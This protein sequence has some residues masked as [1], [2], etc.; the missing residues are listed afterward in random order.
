MCRSTRRPL[1]DPSQTGTP[2]VWFSTNITSHLVFARFRS[3]KKVRGVVPGAGF[4]SMPKSTLSD[5]IVSRNTI[6][7]SP[8]LRLP[9]IIAVDSLPFGDSLPRAFRASCSRCECA[10]HL[11]KNFRHLN[12]RPARCQPESPQS[13]RSAGQD[14]RREWISPE[15][16]CVAENVV[17]MFESRVSTLPSR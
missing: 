3:W 17:P 2:L 16:G 13:A 10:A 9:S 6:T 14:Y 12:R 15:C 1:S 4:Q 7:L 8:V 11:P 5:L